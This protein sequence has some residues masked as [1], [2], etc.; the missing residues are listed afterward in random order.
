MPTS[1]PITLSYIH[2]IVAALHPESAIDIGVGHGKTGV[3]A[4][5]YWEVDRKR[6][7]RHEWKTKLYG[8]E[9]F[10]GYRNPLWDYAYDEVL[11]C[12][13]LTGLGRLPDVDLILAL[14]VWEHFERDYAASVLNACLEKGRFLLI[15]TPIVPRPQGA[16]F[17]NDY[18]R[19][20]SVWTPKDFR[21]VRYR[22]FNSTGENWI[23]IL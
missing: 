8:I 7:H 19:H 14:D 11:V 1:Q 13:A 5:E 3:I 10:P 21:H 4:R 22:L 17:G 15:C 23:M 12:D 2:T 16:V 18:E 9:P 6:F 20:V